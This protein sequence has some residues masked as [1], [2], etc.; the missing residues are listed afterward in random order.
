[1]A[2]GAAASADVTWP[3]EGCVS[4]DGDSLSLLQVRMNLTLG[5]DSSAASRSKMQNMQLQKEEKT[6]NGAQGMQGSHHLSSSSLVQVREWM[7]WK[8]ATDMA[9]EEIANGIRTTSNLGLFE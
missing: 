9:V 6:S 4:D 7:Q 8:V 3:Q 1:M 2:Y 5:S